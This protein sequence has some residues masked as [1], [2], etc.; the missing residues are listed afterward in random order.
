MAITKV[1]YTNATNK[2][3]SIVYDNDTSIK[4]TTL[5]G[6][7]ENTHWVEV[8]EWVAAGNTITAHDG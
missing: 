1:Q 2:V 3:V 7:T 4:T 8:Q 6:N 5:V